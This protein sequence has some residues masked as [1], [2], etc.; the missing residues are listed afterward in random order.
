[1]GV[2]TDGILFYGIAYDEDGLWEE[3]KEW[4]YEN[5]WEETFYIRTGT[6]C[7]PKDGW[8]E[9]QKATKAKWGVEIGRHCSDECTMY[10]VAL[11]SHNFSACRGYP[12]EITAEKMALP[13]DADEKIKAFCEL[14][15]IPYEKPKWMLASYV[16]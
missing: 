7:Y 12:E 13:A 9:A 2:S 6:P 1:M 15:G 4:D 14:M 16:G 8:F 11:V 5:D 10:Y 3:S